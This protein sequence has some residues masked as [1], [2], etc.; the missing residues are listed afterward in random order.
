MRYIV[1][2]NTH[3]HCLRHRLGWYLTIAS[4]EEENDIEDAIFLLGEYRSG[5]NYYICNIS[6]WVVAILF[7]LKRKRKKGPN[8]GTSW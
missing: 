7:D 8:N 4:K 2:W 1:G 5:L 3:E 6:H